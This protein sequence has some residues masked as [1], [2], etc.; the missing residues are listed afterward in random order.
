MEVHELMDLYGHPQRID[1]SPWMSM[2]RWI[3]MDL[4]RESMDPHGNPHIVDVHENPWK[5]M[6]V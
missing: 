4:H 3:S 5:S 1:G 2:S 6:E